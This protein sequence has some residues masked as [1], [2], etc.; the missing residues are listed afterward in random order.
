[1][2]E[3]F[4]S[5][6]Q[7]QLNNDNVKPLHHDKPPLSKSTSGLGRKPLQSLHL[8][9]SGASS[10]IVAACDNKKEKATVA[11]DAK[12]STSDSADVATSTAASPQTSTS[13]T[14]SLDEQTKQPVFRS[15]VWIDSAT[16]SDEEE[17]WTLKRATPVYDSDEDE[18]E[19]T[20]YQ[21][22][23][24]RSKTMSLDWQDRV[25]QQEDSKSDL[26]ILPAVSSSSS[27]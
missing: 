15:T 12:A 1:M 6:Q 26:D 21:S 5:R 14:T 20:Q 13:T 2:T 9:N 17:L 8:N 7:Q 3:A 10:T 23:A 19:F 16:D 4:L 27:C 11:A 18:Q 25:E 24:K 22:P